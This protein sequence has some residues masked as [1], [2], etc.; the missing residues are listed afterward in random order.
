MQ[1]LGNSIWLCHMHLS[2]FLHGPKAQGK[3]SLPASAHLPV[4]RLSLRPHGQVCLCDNSRNIFRIFLETWFEYLWVHISDKFDDG[5]LNSL[6]MCM[7]DLK[8]TLTFFFISDSFVPVRSLTFWHSWNCYQI[9][10]AKWW[11]IRNYNIW[12]FRDFQPFALW[13]CPHS[14]WRFCS[15]HFESWQGYN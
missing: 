9:A 2:F 1:I 12:T 10:P 14:N 8:V 5:Y 4:C 13:I 11:V 6:N 3:L 15:N 7:L